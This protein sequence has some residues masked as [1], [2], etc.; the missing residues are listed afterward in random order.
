MAEKFRSTCWQS[1]QEWTKVYEMIFSYEDLTHQDEALKM[2]DVWRSRGEAKLPVAV[3]CTYLLV[4][5]TKLSDER[6]SPNSCQLFQS[7][8]AIAMALVRFVNGM[9]DQ[10]ICQLKYNYIVEKANVPV[11]V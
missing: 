11:P 2:I 8:L 10:G 9:V 7:R 4:A 1:W 6:S 5:A 3:E